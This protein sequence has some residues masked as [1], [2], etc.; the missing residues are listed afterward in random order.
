M[1][2]PYQ[3]QTYYITLKMKRQEIFKGA[4][5]M[6]AHEIAEVAAM[7]EMLRQLTPQMRQEIYFML[8]GALMVAGNEM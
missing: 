7:I 1:P 5:D 3:R 8:K 4:E 2:P 6:T